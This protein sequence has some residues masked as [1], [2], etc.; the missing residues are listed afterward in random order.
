[1]ESL[2]ILLLIV[3]FLYLNQ[4]FVQIKGSIAEQRDNLLQLQKSLLAK[5]QDRPSS[6]VST[7]PNAPVRPVVPQVSPVLPPVTPPPISEPPVQP[8]F[9]PEPTPKEM[10]P[11]LSIST[12]E[13]P[14]AQKPNLLDDSLLDPPA[15]VPPV[16]AAPKPSWFRRFLDEN[17]DLEKFIGENLINKI[18][19][20]ILVAGIGYFVRYAIS[21][22]WIGEAGRV[23]IGVLAGGGL[24]GVAHRM[25]Q[26]FAAFSSVLVA[27]GLSVLYFTI[28][29]AFSDYKIFSQTAAFL[30][31]VVITGFAVALSIAYNRVE[32]AVMSLIGG[33]ATPFM[34][35]SGQGNY[36]VLFAYILILDLGMLVLSSFRKWPL[37]HWVAYGLTV[38]L[39]G[40]WLATDVLDHIPS[41]DAP[42]PPYSGAFVFGTIFY[43]LFAA[44]NL[45]DRL[46]HDIRFSALDVSLF[47]SNTAFYYGAG[48]GILAYV[49]KGS[50]QGPFTLALAVVNFGYAALLR[51]R[52]SSDTTLFY[53]L[54][55]L[56][57]TFASLTIPV[58]LNGNFITMFWALEAV[59]LLWLSQRSGLRLV[60]T[61]SVIVL[62]LMGISLLMD[63][64]ALY[65]TAVTPPLSVVINKA[66]ITSLVSVGGLGVYYRLLAQQSVPISIYISEWPAPSYRRFVGYVAV[67]VTY[68]AGIEELD[69][70]L[71]TAFGYDANR[72]IL[73]GTYN[74]LVAVAFLVVSL[75]S[76]SNQRVWVAVL[77]SLV[78]LIIYLFNTGPAVIDLL[79]SYYQGLVSS[80]A[81]F[82]FQYVNLLA[83]GAVLGLLFRAKVR[84]ATATPLLEKLWP[85][86][87]VITVVSISSMALF[88]NV[89]AFSFS[90]E[91][92]ARVP[93]QQAAV[94][95]RFDALIEQANKV[96]LPVVWGLCAFAFMYVGLV[97]RNRMYRILSLSLFA[98]TLLKLFIYDI[99][100]ISEG[101]RILAFISLGALLLVISFMYQRIKRLLAAD[102]AA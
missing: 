47:M 71:L 18:G 101:G 73:L 52:N 2:Y 66:F 36:V 21:Q 32:L 13:P 34:V 95:R 29:I 91:E 90:P 57:I 102:A 84:L 43:T 92:I 19:I 63:W 41:P 72:V 67:I 17:P 56:V 55:G 20:A 80:R 96:G 58:Q 51:R 12:P 81:A 42:A 88:A 50:W 7:M 8:A 62:G 31:M 38:L 9:R 25:R 45:F 11:V 23:L 75:R 99:Q 54:I 79:D 15:N 61:A 46:R 35:S 37:V 3:L 10:E 33:F 27:G 53:L 85:W 64:A 78:I 14:R 16:F 89:I 40:S 30:L 76:G 86:F 6:S 28:A 24:L 100:G 68:L 70:Q 26:R 97:R 60:A 87:L 77:F 44:M 65:D 94:Q 1:M 4:Q 82:L 59:L 98:L 49:D 48:M 93:N 5:E 74:L 83:A 22:E 39:F 69:Y